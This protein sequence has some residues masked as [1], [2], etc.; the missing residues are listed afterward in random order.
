MTVEAVRRNVP[1][2]VPSRS[3]DANPLGQSLRL[4][5]S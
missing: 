3:Q 5:H 1:L 4:G 2:S